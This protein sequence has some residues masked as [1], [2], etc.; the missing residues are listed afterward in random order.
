MTEPQNYSA[1]IAT[2]C[3]PCKL[4]VFNNKTN[5][6]T[7]SNATNNTTSN[8]KVVI[9]NLYLNNDASTNQ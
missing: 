8:N 9:N 3:D 7:N 6:I 4:H 2:L 5:N 1:S